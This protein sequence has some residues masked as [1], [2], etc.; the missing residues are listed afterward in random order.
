MAETK[1]LYSTFQLQRKFSRSPEAVFAALSK[2]EKVK[3]W[4]AD[5]RS[6]ETLEFSLR[7]AVGGTRRFVY[8]LGPDTPVAGMVIINDGHFQDIV[9]NQRIVTA[10]TMASGDKCLVASLVTFE[11]LPTDGGTELQ[12]T[13][14]AAYFDGL[15]GDPEGLI[16]GG[17]NGL[18]DRLVEVVEAAG[19]AGHGE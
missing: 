5:G 3:K 18:L 19:S 16:K 9:P 4:F 14:Q 8:R 10:T 13:H 11:L 2:P 7:F 12:C 15:G 1:V 17:W 6:H